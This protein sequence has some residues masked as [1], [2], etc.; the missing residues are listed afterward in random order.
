MAFCDP[1]NGSAFGVRRRVNTQLRTRSDL[2]Y[3]LNF[4]A[5]QRISQFLKGGHKKDPRMSQ[6]FVCGNGRKADAGLNY[7]LCLLGSPQPALGR[8]E[9][10]NLYPHFLPGSLNGPQVVTTDLQF[11][12]NAPATGC[13]HHVRVAVCH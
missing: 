1:E 3:P 11:T 5:L 9:S 12:E 7:S 13:A 4:T 6:V 10:Q 2:S 8:A